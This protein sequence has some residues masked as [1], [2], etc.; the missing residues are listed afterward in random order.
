MAFYSLGGVGATTSLSHFD[1]RVQAL[2]SSRGMEL[3][4][5]PLTAHNHVNRETDRFRAWVCTCLPGGSIT[6]CARLF[7]IL[8]LRSQGREQAAAWCRSLPNH[9]APEC[10]FCTKSPDQ[11]RL[12]RAVRYPVLKLNDSPSTAATGGKASSLP[13]VASLFIPFL[14]RLSP[15]VRLFQLRSRGVRTNPQPTC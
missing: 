2:L 4:G 7:L 12:A 3:S 13:Q 10:S 14:K 11:S 1:V 9:G 8:I 15:C 6:C 5:R